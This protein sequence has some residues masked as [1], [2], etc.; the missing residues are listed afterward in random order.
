MPHIPR[1]SCT[2][3]LLAT[4]DQVLDRSRF[5]LAQHY[6]RVPLDQHE[7]DHGMVHHDGGGGDVDG[8]S[9]D[10]SF[11]LG[12]DES[13]DVPTTPLGGGYSSE[14]P[15]PPSSTY[16]PS[17]SQQ[18]STGS[19]STTSTE[20]VNEDALMRLWYVSAPFEVVRIQDDADEEEPV[21]RP[22][23]LVAVDFGHAVWIEYVE[24][25]QSRKSLG[26]RDVV[27]DPKCLRFVTFPPFSD[28]YDDA[29]GEGRQGQVPMPMGQVRTI[30]HPE[31][32]DLGKV[33]TINIDQSQGAVIL[34]DKDGRIFILCYE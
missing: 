4:H 32:L 28:E 16:T 9:L 8:Y 30:P 34:S 3:V 23:P 6:F 5:V 19:I 13:C 25:E 31:E 26:E 29:V 18:T 14:T 12:D 22:R 33:E 7:W 10:S 2:V 21:T 27:H 1:V 17:S 15:H 11:T 20:D 24:T